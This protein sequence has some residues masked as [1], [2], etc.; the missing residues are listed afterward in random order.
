M[1]SV[2]QGEPCPTPNSLKPHKVLKSKF[3]LCLVSH[4]ILEGELLLESIH[5]SHG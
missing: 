5:C 4:K 3:T 1:K 2:G